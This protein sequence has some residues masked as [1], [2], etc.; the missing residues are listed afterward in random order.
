MMLGN[1]VTE[2]ISALIAAMKNG[3]EE[4]QWTMEREECVVQLVQHCKQLLVGDEQECRCGWA[5]VD[6]FYRHV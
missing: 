6:P 3:T 5:L 1:A 2:D 4:E